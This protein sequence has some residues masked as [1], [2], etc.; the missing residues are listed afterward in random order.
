MANT[1]YLWLRRLHSF[2]GFFPFAIFL[3]IHFTFNSFIYAGPEAFN[4]FVASTQGFPLTIFLEVGL[5]LVPI[6]FHILLGLVIMY[7]G[8][9]NVTSYNLYRNWMYL[10]QR[11]TGFIVVP[12]LLYHVWMT[13]MQ[14]VFTGHHVD[15][16]YMHHYFSS[17]A[18]TLFYV[19]GVTASAFH[20]GNGLATMLITW[21]ITQSHRSQY[22]ASVASWAI[23]V[24]M[25]VW[26]SSLAFAF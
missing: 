10:F 24:V 1:N 4:D 11:I 13:R 21:G 12:F 14:Q 9:A 3:V 19:I 6:A 18:V 20:L 2:L 17:P 5:L 16:A 26:G 23:I 25:A 8:S 7:S 22:L 15:A